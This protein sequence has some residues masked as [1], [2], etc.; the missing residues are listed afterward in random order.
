MKKTFTRVFAV[1]LTALLLCGVMPIMA[2]AADGIDITAAFTDPAFRAAVQAL[3]GKDV[4][5]DTDVAGITELDVSGDVYD[6]GS[7]KSLA[8][9]EY[10]TALEFLSCSHNQI[11]E[12]PD[13]PSSLEKLWCWDNQLTTLPVLPSSLRE[14]VCGGNQLA[15][16]PTLPLG[17]EDL[18]CHDNQLTVLPE[19]PANLRYLLCHSNQL[20]S[21]PALP[22][23][24]ITVWCHDNLL[25]TLPALPM[26]LKNLLCSDNQL[27]SLDLT[28]LQLEELWCFNNNMASKSAVK[29]FTGAWWAIDRDGNAKYVFYPQRFW[30]AWPPFLQWILQYL[31]FGWLWMNWF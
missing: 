17:L 31:L 20:T 29:G 26:G 13:L 30:Y 23:N 3:I 24:L 4:I 7:I 22:S 28:G 25:S 27:T 12:L 6:G 2:S 14:L 18:T 15:A 19:L 11:T 5:L 9:L 21:L 10:F 1:L 8:G 16:L